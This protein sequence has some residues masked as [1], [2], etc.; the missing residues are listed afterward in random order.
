MTACPS[1]STLN[2]Y[3][4]GELKDEDCERLEEHFSSCSHCL[5]EARRLLEQSAIFAKH[6]DE[7][8]ST[9]SAE[10]ETPTDVGTIGSYK[11]LQKIG[12]GGMGI[13]WL[14]EQEKPV[15][16]RVALKLIKGALADKEII[17]RFDAERQALAL[18]NHPNIAQV[19]DADTTADGSPYFVMELV[20]G[21]PLNEYCDRNNLSIHDRLELFV[22]VCQ[23]TQHAHQK[24]IIHRDLKPSNVLVATCDGKPVPKVIDF[25]MAKALDHTQKLTDKTMFTEFGKLVGTLQYMSPEQAEMNSQNVD[26]R[27][28]IYSLGAM[29]YELLTGSPPLDREMIGQ[30]ALFQVLASI[31]EREPQLPS[32]RLSGNGDAIATISHRRKITSGKLRQILRGE[33]DWVVMKALEKDRSRRYESASGFAE[34]IKRYLNDDA[35]LARPP[36]AVYQVQKFVRKHRGLV[37]SVAIIVASLLAGIG[38]TIW[39]AMGE[40]SQR[41]LAQLKSMEATSEAKRAN[42]QD[43]A[44]ASSRTTCEKERGASEAG[45]A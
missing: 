39:F 35:V 24:G 23:A 17:A 13:V 25:G 6:S 9:V 16:R 4:L 10:C 15:K 27:T 18:M 21:A 22:D 8:R 26:I 32:D 1:E 31:R 38:G 40:R 14:A 5:S 43:K 19:L 30:N 37:A 34:D 36:S 33:L 42:E 28:D 45:Q 41:E 11:L 2:S 20:D 7:T 12:E 29:L 3:A 44:G